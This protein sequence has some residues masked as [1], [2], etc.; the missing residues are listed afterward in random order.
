MTQ[1]SDWTGIWELDSI[2]GNRWVQMELEQS[3]N[4]VKGS[5]TDQGRISGTVSG[6]KLRGTWAEPPDYSEPRNKGD[7]EFT[8]SE[9]GNSITG[10]WGLGSSGSWIDQWSGKRTERAVEKGTVASPSLY[11]G[12]AP[13]NTSPYYVPPDP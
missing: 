7:F 3:G 4:A 5:Y 13:N 8:L 11:R 9:D 10:S 12:G 1:G 6:N 2:P